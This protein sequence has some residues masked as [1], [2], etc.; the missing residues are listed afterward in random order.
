MISAEPERTLDGRVAIVTGASRGI[1]AAIAQAFVRAGTSVT[2]AAHDAAALDELASELRADG[3][4]PSLCPPT[5]PTTTSPP[6]R[7]AASGRGHKFR[8]GAFRPPRA[9]FVAR[10]GPVER[11]CLRVCRDRH[12][13]RRTAGA[14]VT[15]PRDDRVVTDDDV[16]H[17]AKVDGFELEERA[18]QDA[19][20]WGWCRGDDRRW[21]CHL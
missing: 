1:G 18:C 21:P 17:E 20:V 10:I 14:R 4:R 19:W 3:D 5:W 7:R 12:R 2:L 8:R 6:G 16:M 15:A 11:D 9:L 13:K